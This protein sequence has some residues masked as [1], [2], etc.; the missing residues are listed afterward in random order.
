MALSPGPLSPGPP[1]VSSVTCWEA[2]DWVGMISVIGPA[3]SLRG[4]TSTARSLIAA[5]MTIGAGG[6]S[7]FLYLWSAEPQEAMLMA[8]ASEQAATAACL[9]ILRMAGH[10]LLILDPDR[11]STPR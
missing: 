3:P 11:T 6:R 2:E 1:S 10:W 9:G 7:A 4:E 8:P 5:L